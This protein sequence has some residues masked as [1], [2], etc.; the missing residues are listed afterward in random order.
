MALR[1]LTSS[2]VPEGWG[3]PRPPPTAIVSR[4]PYW[5]G[6]TLLPPS[7]ILG[8]IDGRCNLATAPTIRGAER[9][10]A[11]WVCGALLLL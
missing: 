8:G 10:K 11:T 4:S 1:I 9:Y 7:P 6:R 3:V 2:D 5:R